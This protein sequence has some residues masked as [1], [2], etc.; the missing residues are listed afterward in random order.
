MPVTEIECPRCQLGHFPDGTVIRPFLLT[1]SDSK[2]PACTL[3]GYS[4][5]DLATV[6]PTKFRCR[7]R[8]SQL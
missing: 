2:P 7:P 4:S 1:R 5:K 8:P 6:V 3:C